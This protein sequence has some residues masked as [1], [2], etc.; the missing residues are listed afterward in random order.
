MPLY[1]GCPRCGYSEHASHGSSFCPKCGHA[2]Q[3]STDTRDFDTERTRAYADF[4]R[5]KKKSE[6][7]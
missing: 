2:L 6:S 5:A 3:A 4:Q 7:F 1:M